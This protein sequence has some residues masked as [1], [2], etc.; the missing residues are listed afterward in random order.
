MK[1]RLL[2]T[3]E[4]AV[5]YPCQE[6]IIQQPLIGCFVAAALY[7]GV[8]VVSH[9]GPTMND[10]T[11]RYQTELRPAPQAPARLVILN[12]DLA[13][14]GF[15]SR[16]QPEYR[17]LHQNLIAMLA[18]G[19]Q[20]KPQFIEKRI[21]PA[22]AEMTIGLTAAGRLNFPDFQVCKSQVPRGFSSN[23]SQPEQ[24]TS[25]T[26]AEGVRPGRLLL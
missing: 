16:S 10:L 6:V 14:T 22:L 26:V 15:W 1:P 11:Y 25:L 23:P 19:L 24:L 13:G 21:Y 20:V 18:V 9:C 17:L 8:A 12:L 7:S 3:P 4:A 5:I 2:R